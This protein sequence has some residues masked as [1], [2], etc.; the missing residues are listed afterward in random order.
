VSTKETTREAK[1][2]PRA[3][4]ERDFEQERRALRQLIDH[5]RAEPES[6]DDGGFYRNVGRIIIRPLMRPHW[7]DHKRH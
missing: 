7:P 3:S 6:H 4:N 2:G 5:F 1:R